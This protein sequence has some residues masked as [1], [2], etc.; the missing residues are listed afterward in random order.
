MVNSSVFF[1]LSFPFPLAKIHNTW[2]NCLLIELGKIP[3]RG[4]GFG[5]YGKR[6]EHE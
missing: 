6:S 3:R 1:T 4:I 5:Y 2:Y